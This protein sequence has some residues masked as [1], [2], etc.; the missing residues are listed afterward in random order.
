MIEILISKIDLILGWF[1]GLV[2][3]LLMLWLSHFLTEKSSFKKRKRRAKEDFLEASNILLNGCYSR[4]VGYEDDTY[5]QLKTNI[6]LSMDGKKDGKLVIH[7][8]RE[9]LGHL[10]VDSHI[11]FYIESEVWDYFDAYRRFIIECSFLSVS[12]KIFSEQ[13]IRDSFVRIITP[14]ELE[15]QD[16]KDQPLGVFIS[17]IGHLLFK[18]L[19]EK[20]KLVEKELN[21]K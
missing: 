14:L 3:S 7:K 16:Q 6:S 15:F 4:L 21:Q 18:K 11:K 17:K 10:K 9:D 1:L 5:E 13:Q 20:V 2:G 8:I 19:H 12:V